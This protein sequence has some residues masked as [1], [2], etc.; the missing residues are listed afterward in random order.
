M[1]DLSPGSSSH[2]HREST[3]LTDSPVASVGAAELSRRTVLRGAGVAALAVGAVGVLAA[4]APSGGTTTPAAG[5]ASST[6]GTGSGTASL[7]KVD[8]I[9]VG[10]AILVK[11][12]AGKP[13]ILSQPTAGTVV[14]MTAICTHMGCTVAPAGAQLVCPCHG[15]VYKS[16]D[17]SNVSGPAP[18]PL[19]AVTV[20]VVNG[21]V[22]AG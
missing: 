10:G 19:A 3:R 12:A 18:K 15:S 14:A 21:E 4:C 17:G 5:G 20:H 2:D 8:A 16:A 13:V 6:G 7:A 11:D 1:S 9:P 22:L